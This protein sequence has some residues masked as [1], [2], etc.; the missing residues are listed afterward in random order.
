MFSRRIDDGGGGTHAPRV[1]KTEAEW[2][3]QLSAEQYRILRRHGTERAFSSPL[4]KADE[5]GLYHCAGCHAALFSSSTKYHSG[6]GWPSFYQ[7]FDCAIATSMDFRLIVPRTEIHCAQ[8]GGHLGHV[9]KDG[10]PPTGQRYCVNGTAL[11]FVPA[12]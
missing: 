1:V 3:Q 11:T 9:F 12:R 5:P 6:S 7:T 2:Q 10:P 8:C 4:E